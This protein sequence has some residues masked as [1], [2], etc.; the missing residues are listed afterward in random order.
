MSETIDLVSVN[1]LH[2]QFIEDASGALTYQPIQPDGEP[3]FF[4]QTLSTGGAIDAAAVALDT[5]GFEA[6]WIQQSTD[7]SS[8]ALVTRLMGDAIT[9]DG[10]VRP[11]INL[12]LGD[13]TAPQL[14]A[15]DVGH[16]VVTYDV[17][18]G[19]GMAAE[20]HVRLGDFSGFY[21]DLTVQSRPDHITETS[22]TI[23][24]DWKT[25]Q[26][27]VL[28]I[29]GKVLSTFGVSH[30]YNLT[31]GGSATIQNF[32][33]DHDQIR[34]NNL[35]GGIAGG[36][37]STLTFDERTHALTWDQDSPEGPSPP[38]SAGVV[39]TGQFGVANLAAD[40]RP[41]VLKVIADDGSS[42]ITWFDT[43][44]SQT[45]NTLFATENPAGQVLTYGSMSDGGIK[46]VFTFDVD[47]SQPWQRYVDDFDLQ[48]HVVNRAVLY[49]DGSS[50]NARYV[51][52]GDDVAFYELTNFDAHGNQVGHG[53]YDS[54]G[55]LLS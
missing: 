43:D 30:T 5:S 7:P 55:H 51:F 36:A 35:S 15:L 40:F 11:N 24:L 25:G 44:H 14:Q 50:W 18:K 23:Q 32:N 53:F 39:L 38:V 41:A 8:G 4:H 22:G 12:P 20:T 1:G 10:Q 13:L 28:G 46:E 2:V 3:F 17:D 48:G 21:T 47:N 49:D 9:E 45:W 37:H 19:Q 31:V 52:Q 26:R 29:D 27:E 54:N 6:V 34:L 33:A 42:T 16:Y